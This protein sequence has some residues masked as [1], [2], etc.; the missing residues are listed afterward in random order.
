MVM[1]VLWAELWFVVDVELCFF[2]D[3]HVG[4]IHQGWPA[5]ALPLQY[6]LSEHLDISISYAACSTMVHVYWPSVKIVATTK[7]CQR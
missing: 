3:D 1:T 5:P 4:I 2:S 6:S 7:V